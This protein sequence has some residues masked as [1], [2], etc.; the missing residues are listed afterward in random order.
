MVAL[1]AERMEASLVDLT[2]GSK[3]DWMVEQTVV[4]RA[5]LMVE[6]RAVEK[7]E[8]LGHQ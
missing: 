1:M 3:V 4:L 2:V 5:D 7:A 8:Q 6:Q